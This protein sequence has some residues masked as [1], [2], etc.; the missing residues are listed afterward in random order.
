MLKCVYTNELSSAGIKS[1]LPRKTK[2]LEFPENSMSVVEQSDFK[3]SDI[4]DDVVLVTNSIFLISCFKKEE[5]RLYKNNNLEKPSFETYGS[6]F[7]VL[8]KLLTE[9]KSLIP[10]FIVQ[11]IREKI[12]ESDENAIK[13][14]KSLG[15]SPEK[16]YLEK[17]LKVKKAR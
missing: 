10:N 8:F 13:Y 6:S 15:M 16:A 7:D 12:K 1:F 4:N 2:L 11:E 14:L 17:V 5:V 9:R 3:P